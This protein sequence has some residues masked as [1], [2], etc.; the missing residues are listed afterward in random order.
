MDNNNNNN[1]ANNNQ[2]QSQSQQSQQSQSSSSTNNTIPTQQN[3]TNGNHTEFQQITPLS[4]SIPRVSY[5]N[6]DQQTIMNVNQFQLPKSISLPP[7][8]FN[9]GEFQNTLSCMS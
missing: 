1:N 6:D 8:E 4:P 2:S 3:I 7:D 9:F 5:I